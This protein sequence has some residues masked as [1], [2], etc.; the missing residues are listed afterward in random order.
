MN[1]QPCGKRGHVVN[2]DK[3]FLYA[4]IGIAV[5]AV[6]REGEWLAQ[7]NDWS[8]TKGQLIA[9]AIF[10]LVFCVGLVLF[11]LLTDALGI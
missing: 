7:R 11:A 6:L 8:N 3:I 10:A 4:G 1:S 5:P 9:F 2:W